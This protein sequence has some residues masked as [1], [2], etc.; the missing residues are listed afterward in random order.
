M[1]KDERIKECLKVLTRMR[2]FEDERK[3]KRLAMDAINA[4]DPELAKLDEAEAFYKA[5]DG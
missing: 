5:H 1:T 2:Y 4:L 3:I